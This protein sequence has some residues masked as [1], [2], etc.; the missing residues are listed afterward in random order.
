[1]DK[2][3]WL[4]YFGI[5]YGFLNDNPQYLAAVVER[6]HKSLLV[7]AVKKNT[8]AFDLFTQTYPNPRNPET[9]TVQQ[10]E[11]G[12]WYTK[13]P[14]RLTKFLDDANSV[15]RI[16]ATED[17]LSIEFIPVPKDSWSEFALL[18]IS[19]V[20]KLVAYCVTNNRIEYYKEPP[21]KS[22]KLDLVR[23]FMDYF[24]D[25][26]VAIPESGS[27]GGQYSSEAIFEQHVNMFINGTPEP[28]KSNV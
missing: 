14:V 6:A 9:I 1:M 13:S 4:D 23:L 2:R 7:D 3:S 25:E 26:E 27:G 15:R 17:Q 28:N 11:Y 8:S 18:D 12:T 19:K 16:T 22:I 20:S 21:L 5:R 10:D 24:D